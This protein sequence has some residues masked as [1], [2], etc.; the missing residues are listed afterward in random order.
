[1]YS[2]NWRTSQREFDVLR[3]QDVAIP[4]SA[5]IKLNCDIFRPDARGKFPVLLGFHAY[6][7]EDQIAPLMPIGTGGIRGHMEA[8][9]Y[10][11][12]VRRG[13]AHVIAIVRG[14]G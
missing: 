12:Y 14:T 3:E 8:G 5:G 9:D 6:S 11:F 10:N 1:M 2:A 7:M 4:V 13:Y